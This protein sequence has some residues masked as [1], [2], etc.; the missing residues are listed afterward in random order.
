MMNRSENVIFVP[1]KTHT[2]TRNVWKSKCMYI[3]LHATAPIIAD[4]EV[5]KR[6]N[7]ANV[8]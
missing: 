1:P 6:K 2:H 3:L 7:L 4:S 5:T 8:N